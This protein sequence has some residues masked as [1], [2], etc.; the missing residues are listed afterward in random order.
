MFETVAYFFDDPIHLCDRNMDVIC[1][2]P[3][4]INC[5]WFFMVAAHIDFKSVAGVKVSKLKTQERLNLYRV[6]QN[7]TVF[8]L[9]NF[10]CSQVSTT[11]HNFWAHTHVCT[12]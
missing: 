4:G 3:G 10:F 12:L 6:G 2:F 7:C 5:R 8:H 11:F 1:G 9:S